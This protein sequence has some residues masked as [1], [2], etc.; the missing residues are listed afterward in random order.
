MQQASQ[1]KQFWDSRTEQ[2][3]V[4]LLTL[5]VSGLHRQAARLPD[6]KGLAE[7]L[8]QGVRRLAQ[9]GTWKQWQWDA[10]SKPHT[11]AA[12]FRDWIVQQRVPHSLQSLLQQIQES[13]ASTQALHKLHTKLHHAFGFPVKW[14]VWTLMLPSERDEQPSNE[15]EDFVLTLRIWTDYLLMTLTESL[16]GWRARL[17]ACVSWAM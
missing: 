11:S 4:E 2:Q 6:Q 3:R 5:D 1:V 16:R 15:K 9:T 12:S 14:A 10:S 13:A 17:P 8:A 7:V